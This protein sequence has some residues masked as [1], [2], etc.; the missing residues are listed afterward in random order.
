MRQL[1]A[2]QRCKRV[3]YVSPLSVFTHAKPASARVSRSSSRRNKRAAAS[4]A[5]SGHK[6]DSPLA[7]KSG[8]AKQTAPASSVKNSRAKVVLPPQLVP[9]MIIQRGDDRAD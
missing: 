4:A 6:G 5:R 7:I 9:A 1:A 3:A 8:L 2:F